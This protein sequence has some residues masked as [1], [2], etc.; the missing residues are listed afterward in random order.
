MHSRALYIIVLRN[1][2][3]DLSM[4]S[5]G[6]KKEQKKNTNEFNSVVS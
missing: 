1:Q 3:S 5:N 4:I 2:G 6:L